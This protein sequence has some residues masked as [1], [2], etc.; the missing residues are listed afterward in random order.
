MN[1]K[2][3]LIWRKTHLHKS[4]ISKK[5]CIVTLVF[6][7]IF[8]GEGNGDWTKQATTCC[9]CYL[10]VKKG[11]YDLSLFHREHHAN[12]PPPPNSNTQLICNPGLEWLSVGVFCSLVYD[13]VVKECQLTDPASTHWPLPV[14]YIVSNLHKRTFLMSLVLKSVSTLMT[15]IYS[16]LNISLIS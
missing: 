14:T 10:P 6:P 12:D 13:A 15:T 4:Q 16:R 7:V 5:L 2:E 8:H 1:C 3:A 11:S 9:M